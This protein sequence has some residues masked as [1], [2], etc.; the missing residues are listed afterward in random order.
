LSKKE[1]TPQTCF[2][3]VSHMVGPWPLVPFLQFIGVTTWN[4]GEVKKRLPF[5]GK[6]FGGS[7][8]FLQKRNGT[9]S[10]AGQGQPGGKTRTWSNWSAINDKTGSSW[11]T[12]TKKVGGRNAGTSCGRTLKK[13]KVQ[14]SPRARYPP[15]GGAPTT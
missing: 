6:N 9:Q 1:N 14:T 5:A 11:P 10:G 3:V 12:K 4:T 13:K 2:K 15:R 8:G 7:E